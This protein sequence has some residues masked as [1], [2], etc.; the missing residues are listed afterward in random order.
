M[1]VYKVMGKVFLKIQSQNLILPKFPWQSV[2]FW[3]MQTSLFFAEHWLE[4]QFHLMIIRRCVSK[5][6]SPSA[7]TCGD[8]H[9]VHT[10]R[11]FLDVIY[12]VLIT[13]LKHR[14]DDLKLWFRQALN[15][16]SLY[17]HLWVKRWERLLSGTIPRIQKMQMNAG[18]L[19]THLKA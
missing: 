2:I 9:L 18:S 3:I 17:F 12:S 1:E 8:S 13:S 10:S 16:T 15:S 5:M 19:Q 11:T 14:L 7:E 6:F 4:T